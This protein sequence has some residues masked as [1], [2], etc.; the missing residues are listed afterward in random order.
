MHLQ[1][2]CQAPPLSVSHLVAED[3]VDLQ[4]LTALAPGL[5]VGSERVHTQFRPVNCKTWHTRKPPGVCAASSAFAVADASQLLHPSQRVVCG[6]FPPSTPP[7]LHVKK[8]A[9][10]G[11]IQL[12]AVARCTCSHHGGP[13]ESLASHTCGAASGIAREHDSRSSSEVTT[14]EGA[15]W[16]SLDTA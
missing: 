3:G 14:S 11:G 15:F 6:L 5:W 7:P 2:D 8:E 10:L 9:W 12:A 1:H 16:R 4:Q 13:A